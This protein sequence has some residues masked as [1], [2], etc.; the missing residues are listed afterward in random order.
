MAGMAS[1][2]SNFVKIA[3]RL[4][5]TDIE[6]LAN[7]HVAVTQTGI[8]VNLLRKNDLESLFEPYQFSI[9]DHTGYR[10]SLGLELAT[11]KKVAEYASATVICLFDAKG[12]LEFQ[13]EIPVKV[14]ATVAPA[15][16]S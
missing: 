10:T 2:Q 14:V 6:N 16:P 3:L 5:P 9:N 15:L 11:C 8:H 13:A 1:H 12:E 7:L 4:E